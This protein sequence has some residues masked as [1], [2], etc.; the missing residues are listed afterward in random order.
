MANWFDTR[1]NCSHWFGRQVESTHSLSLSSI[2]RKIKRKKNE[3]AARWIAINKLNELDVC[4]NITKWPLIEWKF[5]A[6]GVYNSA[7]MRA[8]SLFDHRRAVS[9]K[10]YYGF[11]RT[12]SR[13]HRRTVRADAWIYFHCGN[14]HGSP[15]HVVIYRK[16]DPLGNRV[17]RFGEK[18]GDRIVSTPRSIIQRWSYLF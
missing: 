6:K 2:L 7:R 15:S 5:L 4:S 1:W 16:D 14:R 11:R 18:G 12:D 8:D 17:C 3:T 13:G 10:N 9:R